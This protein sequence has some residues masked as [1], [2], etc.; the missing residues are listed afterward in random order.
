MITHI[1]KPDD[2]ATEE[3]NLEYYGPMTAEFEAVDD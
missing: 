3:I 2:K 1:L